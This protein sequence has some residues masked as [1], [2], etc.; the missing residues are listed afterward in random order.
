[1]RTP[2]A[3]K[4]ALHI[5]ARTHFVAKPFVRRAKPFAWRLELSLQLKGPAA[6]LTLPTQL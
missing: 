1:M 4:E 6:V 5:L 2:F 3:P